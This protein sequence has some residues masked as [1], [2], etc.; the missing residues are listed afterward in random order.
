[1]SVND[2]AKARLED[3]LKSLEDQKQ[4]QEKRFKLQLGKLDL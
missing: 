2:D 3:E 1:M 4:A